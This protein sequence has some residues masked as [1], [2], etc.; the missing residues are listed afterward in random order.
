MSSSDLGTVVHFF[1]SFAISTWRRIAFVWENNRGKVFETTLTQDLVFSIFEFARKTDLP[2]E[3]WESHDETANG[4]DLEIAVETSKGYVLFPCQ[5]KVIS[6][7][8]KYPKLKYSV[9][10]VPQIDLLLKYASD[11]HGMGVYLFYNFCKDNKYVKEKLSYNYEIADVYGCSIVPAE[12]LNECFRTRIG[13]EIPRFQDLHPEKG[14]PLHLFFE[15]LLSNTA[16]SN[17]CLRYYYETACPQFL[18]Y[19]QLFSKE[20]WRNLTPLPKISGPPAVMTESKVLMKKKLAYNPRFRIIV[21]AE[22]QRVKISY[23]Y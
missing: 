14:I 22:K 20:K 1:K 16:F 19:D 5:A 10:R 23:R 3:L 8:N 18:S 15:E 11:N 9:R 21:S 2:F 7:S 17:A 6:K 12:F 13:W 4:N